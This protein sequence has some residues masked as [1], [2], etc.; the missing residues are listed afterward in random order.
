MTKFLCDKFSL[1]VCTR[2]SDNFSMKIL[3]KCTRSKFD[4]LA[5]KQVHLS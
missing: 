4:M 1:L 3:K 5:F 2:D